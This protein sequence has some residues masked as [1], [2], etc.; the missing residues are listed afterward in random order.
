MAGLKNLLAG[1]VLEVKL[2]PNEAY[3]TPSG[4]IEFAATLSPAGAAPLPTQQTL[5]SAESWFVLLNSSTAKYTH[6][7]FTDVYG[8]IPQVVWVNPEDAGQRSIE[9]NDLVAVFN[10]LATVTLY[11]KVTAKVPSGTLW[12]PRP[13]TGLNGVPLNALV[14]GIFQGIGGGP[15]FNSVKVKIRLAAGS[16]ESDLSNHSRAGKETCRV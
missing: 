13:L 8:P 6:S 3:Q 4:K 12:A 16:S 15:I 5:P 1:E 11:A 7:Q 14:P 10:E 2:K 9:E